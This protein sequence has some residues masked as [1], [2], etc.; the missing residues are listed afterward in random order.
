MHDGP[1]LARRGTEVFFFSGIGALA[2][3]I[4]YVILVAL[5]EVFALDAMLA[6]TIGFGASA[7][8]NY[9]LNYHLTFTSNKPHVEAASKFAMIAVLGLLLNALIMG[10]G[11]RALHIHYIIVQFGATAIVLLWNFA[12]NY[13]WSFKETRHGDK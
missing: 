6:S 5:V 4:Q 10:F 2:T 8:V 7:C 9:L 12:G 1:S 13:L 11:T 3:G